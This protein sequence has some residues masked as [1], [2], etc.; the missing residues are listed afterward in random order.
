L[1]LEKKKGE[2]IDAYVQV[3]TAPG[4]VDIIMYDPEH[5]FPIDAREAESQEIKMEAKIAGPHTFCIYNS[6]RSGQRQVVAFDYEMHIE[7]EKTTRFFKQIDAEKE[8]FVRDMKK[9]PENSTVGEA[10]KKGEI[11]KEVFLKQKEKQ[12]Q[13]L[14]Q[15][16]M[17]VPPW[18]EEE[19]DSLVR[20]FSKLEYQLH[21]MDY[22][23]KKH[24]NAMHLSSS[25]MQAMLDDVN[26]RSVL[27]CFLIMLIGYVQIVI[28]RSFF[29]GKIS[30]NVWTNV[31]N[32]PQR[33]SI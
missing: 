4:S 6:D 31:S 26:D 16:Q 5:T 20:S 2:Q 14:H 13:E 9:V 30:L 15:E 3:L 18:I 21:A 12:V 23:L 28:V 33:T 29:T 11:K 24:N 1:V 22:Y 19:F 27:I 7:A 17:L 8:K 32:E 25:L 10:V